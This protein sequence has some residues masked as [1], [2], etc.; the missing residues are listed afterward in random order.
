MTDTPIDDGKVIQVTKLGDRW[1]VV[2]HAPAVTVLV[3]RSGE[4]GEEVLLVSQQRPAIG[5]KTW[6]LPAGLIDKGETPEGAAAR[7]LAEEVG[8]GGTLTKLAEFYSSPGFTD[9][10]IFLFEATNTYE[11]HLPGDEDE[12]FESAWKPLL[13]VYSQI[14]RG[15]LASSSPTLLGLTHALGRLGKLP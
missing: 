10:K 5:C 9:E 4:A 3:L 7:E 2:R 14:A 6:E 1:E 8:L 11:A 12:D 13:E 15:K